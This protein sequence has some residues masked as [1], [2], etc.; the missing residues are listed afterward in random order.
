MKR[1]ASIFL[2]G[3]LVASAGRSAT[4][5]DTAAP[6]RARFGVTG[7]WYILPHE[8]DFVMGIASADPPGCTSR[9]ATTTRRCAPAPRSA[10]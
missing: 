4:A 6:P 7:Y 1:L 9:G 5:A 3:A 10:A 2:A 8:P